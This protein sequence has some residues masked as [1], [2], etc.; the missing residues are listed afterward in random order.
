MDFDYSEGWV[1]LH[2]KTIFSMVFKNEGLFKIWMWCLMKASHKASWVS[3]KVGRGISSIEVLPGQF[4]FGRKAA[5]KELNMDE[6]TIYKRIKTLKKHKNITIESNNKYSIISIVNWHSYQEE[7]TKS[8]TENPLQTQTA[9]GKLKKGQKGN[10]LKEQQKDILSCE[11]PSVCD[12]ENK[13]SNIGFYQASNNQVTHTTMITI[14]DKTKDIFFTEDIVP[15]DSK[16]GLSDLDK[17]KGTV[18]PHKIII[19]VYH[20]LC[21]SLPRVQSWNETSQ[22]VLAT[23]WRENK[24]RQEIDWWANY[25]NRVNQS[26]FLTGKVVEFTATLNWLIGPKNMEKVLNGTYDNRKAR[27]SPKLRNNIQACQDFIEGE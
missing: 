17:K 20:N 9:I 8:N 11:N 1:C 23:R 10:T 12:D 5:A 21:P 19:E 13:K 27:M 2:R 18:C 26:D 24:E 6:S 22:K 15:E 16:N 4:V 3:I 25:F 7:K 14:K